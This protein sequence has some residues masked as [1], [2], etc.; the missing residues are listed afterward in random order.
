MVT[1][2][3]QR[4]HPAK[5]DVHRHCALRETTLPMSA[6]VRSGMIQITDLWGPA[7]AKSKLFCKRPEA[8]R[9]H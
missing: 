1:R 2:W 5:H 9:I 8:G 4:F 3:A 6:K 7:T